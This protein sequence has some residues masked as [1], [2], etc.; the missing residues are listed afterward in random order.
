MILKATKEVLAAAILLAA[1]GC[2]ENDDLKQSRR[3]ILGPIAYQTALRSWTFEFWEG[4]LIPGDQI[5][6]ASDVINRTFFIPVAYKPNSLRQDEE[7][8]A[9]STLQRVLLSDIAR[10][11]EYQALNLAK[12]IGR[13]HIISKRDDHVEIGV[14]AILPLHE[15]S[16]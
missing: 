14:N 9:I 2:W 8:G 6:L 7:S 12:S 13:I 3:F 11:Q 15:L 5:Q 10:E 16:I 1:F 4:D